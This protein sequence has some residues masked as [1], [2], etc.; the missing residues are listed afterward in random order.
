MDSGTESLLETYLFE[1]GSLIEKVE[2]LI[3]S[4]EEIGTFSKEEV[5][6]IFRSMH[7]IKGASAMLEFQPLMKV[8]HRMEDLFSEIRENGMSHFND[9][10]KGKLYDLLFASTDSIKENLSNVEQ[11][12]PLNEY[13]EIVEEIE[14]F[15]AEIKGEAGAPARS[16]TT[17]KANV[18]KESIGF[19]VR[20]FFDEN[21]G[22]EHIRAFIIVNALRDSGLDFEFYPED[23]DTNEARI[24]YLIEHGFLVTYFEAADIDKIIEV[25]SNFSFIRD[26]QVVNVSDVLDE[27]EQKE[28]K[29]PAQ[30]TQVPTSPSVQLKKKA[31]PSTSNGG[32][33]EK[34][35]KNSLISVSLDKLD[36]LMKV[37]GE[38]VI[39]E[40]MVVSA[41][42]SEGIQNE[43]FDKSTRELKKL[44]K[45]LQD[46]AMSLRMVPISGS[47]N[48]MN[49]IVR[50]MCKSLNKDV[51]L[52]TEGG[53][54]QMDKSIVDNI[55]DPLMH[56]VRNAMDH[57]IES[58]A[59]DR[60]AAGKSAKGEIVLSAKNIGG[61]VVISVRDDGGGINTEA[62]L[63]K[64]ER[65]GILT[66]PKEAYSEKESM[67]LI[68]APGFSMNQ[69][70]SEYSGRGVGM[71]VVKRNVESIGGKVSITRNED[72]GT[73]FMLKI[74]L[75][76]AIVDGMQIAM[77]ENSFTIPILNI[78]QS[79]IIKK[80]EVIR[81]ASGNE[82]LERRGEFYPFIKLY[83]ALQLE[84]CETDIEKGIVMW[85]EYGDKNFYLFVDGL[86]GE[87]QVVVKPIPI[88]LN[89]FKIKEQGISGCTILGD[90]NISLILDALN[91]YNSYMQNDN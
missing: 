13:S 61:D 45:D 17:Q 70:I 11:E 78:K 67:E 22:M 79:F 80:E 25:V 71:D 7:T 27:K 20:F 77:G 31:A 48:K 55:A 52:I 37:I 29:K 57:G 1:S 53:D 26:C 30:T 82:M 5:D 35:V 47:F 65:V 49:R 87:A 8:A 34:T 84:N 39:T 21:C 14:Q 4:T 6:E 32:K 64:A 83:E 42:E 91:I 33:K 73:T 41:I 69:E 44:T 24:P 3:I 63:N 51:E 86:V 74:P 90:G 15:L 62:V 72:A 56:I 81:D 2:E 76:L 23:V 89:K 9:A 60:V 38:I 18:A 50:D 16:N 40:S 43:K 88:Y 12:E 46:V 58:N 85:L 10:Q 59:E 36:D 28:V 75:T 19:K 54:A 66:K 68:M